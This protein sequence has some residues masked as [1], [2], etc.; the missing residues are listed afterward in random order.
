MKFRDLDVGPAPQ[1]PADAY[2]ARRKRLAKQLGAGDALV[3]AT[4]T[5]K[6]YANDVDFPFRPHS[7]FWYLTGFNEPGAVLVLEGGSGRAT[8]LVRDREPEREIWTGRRLGVA[9]AAQALGVDAA[10]AIGEL[11]ARLPALL[12]AAKH[13]HAITAHDPG[14]HAR[15]RKAAGKRLV[16]EPAKQQAGGP[17][18]SVL[19]GARKAAAAAAPR[20]ARLMLAH[21]RSR[22]EPA[23]MRLL[24]KACDLG[25]DAHLASAALMR[26]GKREF[27]VE[28]AFIHHARSRGSTGVGYPSICGCG[29]NAAILHYV[30][31]LSSL[32]QGQMFLA[33][34]G[35]EWGY[36]TSDITR[37]YPVG[38]SFADRRQ[39]R[40][41]ELV[42]QAQQA[43]LKLVRP[44]QSFRAPHDKAVDVIAAGLVEEGLVKGSFEKVVADKTYR[45]FFM[46]GTSHFLGLDVHDAGITTAP[47]G[48][49]AKLEEG[50]V[51]TVEPGL[52]F[53]PDFAPCPPGTKGIGIRIEDD[54]AVTDGAPRNLTRRLPVRPA[55]VAKLVR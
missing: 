50:M 52:Y 27:E 40:L 49:A 16:P 28:A 51:I 47:D 13:V 6:V 2:A 20:H 32:R 10:Y 30:S 34:M 37:T 19:K 14:V 15:V 33:D 8:V 21:L 45:S 31:N 17:D 44:G 41:Y 12:R 42:L 53:N 36:Y 7:D 9:R 55:D 5:V 3:V 4:H 22:K 54:V 35:C 23:E 46:H 18:S 11:A 43:A 1:L 38:G 25:V 39:E 48:K 24:Q 26:D 29:P